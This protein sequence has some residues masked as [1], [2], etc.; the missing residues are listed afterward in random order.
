MIVQSKRTNTW[1]LSSKLLALPKMY[2]FQFM[3]ISQGLFWVLRRVWISWS[4]LFPIPSISR[5]PPPSA[6]WPTN[7]ILPHWA[8]SAKDTLQDQHH[9]VSVECQVILLMRY[10]FTETRD[11]W[12]T[13]TEQRANWK[14][15]IY[16]LMYQEFSLTNS[17]F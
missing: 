5:P 17:R 7:I 1:I 13:M 11:H 14:K 9:H 8:L 6:H 4:L 15:D 16:R 10:H 12:N 3:N 2:S